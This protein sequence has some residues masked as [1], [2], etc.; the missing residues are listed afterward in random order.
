MSRQLPACD[1]D[2]CPPTRCKRAGMANKQRLVGCDA[3]VS[4]ADA[5]RAGWTI[6][7]ENAGPE[8]WVHYGAHVHHATKGSD[9][10]SDPNAMWSLQ[11]ARK[12]APGGGAKPKGNV[13]LTVHVP[14]DVR[15]ALGSKPGEVITALVRGSNDSDKAAAGKKPQTQKG[16]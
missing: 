8:D 11:D 4:L 13:K 12:R 6:R 1:H 7:C 3:I 14:P 15:E 16:E 9:Y 5:R 2:E 10:K